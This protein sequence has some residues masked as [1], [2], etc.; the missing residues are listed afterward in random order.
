M[1]AQDDAASPTRATRNTTLAEVAERAGVSLKTASRVFNGEP[2]VAEATRARVEAAAADLGFRLN[3]QASMLRKGIVSSELALIVGDLTNPFYAGLAKGM[4]SSLRERGLYLTLA[5]SDEDEAEERRLLSEFARRNVLGVALVSTLADHSFLEEL[6]RRGIGLV[7]VDRPPI[8]LDADSVVLDNFGGG[9]AATRHLLD[10]G[11]RRI[12]FIGD[13]RRLPTHLDRVRGF[14]A[15]MSEAG[16][17]DPQARIHDGAHGASAASALAGRLLSGPDA[18]TAILAGN[19][20]VCLGVL[21]AVSAVAPQT[22][23]IGFDRPEF[24]PL[25][26]VTTS[27]HSPEHMGQVAAELLLAPRPASQLPRHVVLP[28]SISAAGSGERP[29]A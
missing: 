23:V 14:V 21:E 22:A 10:H 1:S 5:S 9:Y 17:P 4:E 6:G 13:Y 16:L 28:M 8:G 18:P 20:R 19:N 25:L 27:W 2:Y 26:K 29:P 24:A 7:L 12:D 15:A 11:H 3:Q